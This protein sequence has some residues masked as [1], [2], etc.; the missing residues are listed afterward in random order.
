MA[1]LRAWRDATPLHLPRDNVQINENIFN[2]NGHENSTSLNYG[3]NN[4]DV[5]ELSPQTMINLALNYVDE[6]VRSDAFAF[7]CQTNK[8]S[9]AVPL[10]DAILI[11]E[12]II[13]NT[14][15]DS[16][17]FRQSI[18]KSCRFLVARLRD[19]IIRELKGC[20]NIL[21]LNDLQMYDLSSDLQ[22]SV[23]LIIWFVRYLNSQLLSNGN[24]Q[25]KILSVQLY[26]EILQAFPIDN[27]VQSKKNSIKSCK[28]ALE[29]I[30]KA[31]K[32]ACDMNLL[33]SSNKDA[34]NQNISLVL[35]KLFI[36]HDQSLKENGEPIVNLILNNTIPTFITL[37]MDE[38]NDIREDTE[39]ILNTISIDSWKK[40]AIEYSQK[41]FSNSC[42][43]NDGDSL[44]DH[45]S[46]T[47]SQEPCENIPIS[48]VL[49]NC[50][51]AIVAVENNSS[52]V[53]GVSH[54][55][56]AGE[57]SVVFGASPCC[58]AGENSVVFGASPCCSLGENSVLSL[59]SWLLTRAVLECDSLKP[60]HAESASLLTKV[61]VATLIR[62]QRQE[63]WLQQVR[64]FLLCVCGLIS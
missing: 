47:P 49:I 3:S 10:K 23:K 5:H 52:V 60:S 53:L 7:L 16:S 34:Q 46:V 54:C 58:S 26:H 4:E 44:Y 2:L 38:M 64:R 33:N 11:Q 9:L 29:L 42:K 45:L 59:F 6:T 27:E 36:F 56:S 39:K 41:H 17:T 63:N 51:E 40:Y 32:L 55:C 21:K 13:Y 35:E 8:A 24:Y 19:T 18:V 62:I 57:K 43:M 31:S 20:P 12:F 50:S 1:V 48:S 15:I 28:N 22:V 14:N 61:T 25:R 30:Y 37:L